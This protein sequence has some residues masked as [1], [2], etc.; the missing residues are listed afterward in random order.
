MSDLKFDKNVKFEIVENKMP[1]GPFAPT[2][3]GQKARV[4]YYTKSGTSYGGGGR[5]VTPTQPVAYESKVLQQSFGSK[6]A[7]QQAEAE[8]YAKQRQEQQK[9]FSKTGGL[10]GV[11]QTSPYFKTGVQDIQTDSQAIRTATT[12]ADQITRQK[13]GVQPGTIGL[14]KT[15]QTK[16]FIGQA[17]DFFT[18]ITA[19]QSGDVE[20]TY[21][22]KTGK[23]TSKIVETQ[24]VNQKDAV[25]SAIK[26][27]EAQGGT[28]TG[29]IRNIPRMSQ[30]GEFIVE[31]AA[32]YP[33]FMGQML[34][35]AKVLQGVSKVTAPLTKPVA[36]VVAK[37]STP[38][39]Q[40]TAQTISG[41]A[42]D[43]YK[44]LSPNVQKGITQVSSKVTPEIVDKGKVLLKTEVTGEALRQAGLYTPE[45]SSATYLAL[46]P[47]RVFKPT[48]KTQKVAEEVYTATRVSYYG[49]T[50]NIVD[51]E[52][53]VIE[54]KKVQ[55]KA[56]IW[57][58]IETP[59]GNLG[60]E[61]FLPGIKVATGF[62]SEFETQVKEKVKDIPEYQALKTPSEKRQYEKEFKD[63]YLNVQQIGG[64]VGQVLVETGGEVTGGGRLYA[65]GPI[66]SR[67]EAAIKFAVASGTT[68]IQE[69]VYTSELG[70]KVEQRKVT[71]QERLTA[72]I[73]GGTIAGG[74]GAAQGYTLGTGTKS[75]VVNIAGELMDFP[76]EPLGDVLGEKV[77]KILNVPDIKVGSSLVKTSYGPSITAQDNKDKQSKRDYSVGQSIWIKTPGV[78]VPGGKTSTAV[79]IKKPSD[80]PPTEPLPGDVPPQEKEDEKEQEK[81]E[82]KEEVPSNVPSFTNVPSTVPVISPQGF[83]LP[84]FGPLGQ[85][86][87]VSR[88][89]RT[90]IYNELEAAGKRFQ[91][92][93]GLG[94]TQPKQ[95]TK[96]NTVLINGKEYKLGKRVKK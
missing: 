84:G 22:T 7:M 77:K 38:V 88:V 10:V 73:M 76:G 30:A 45:V 2:P 14:P 3:E 71:D 34:V 87:G 33:L 12:M 85:A 68:G 4:E 13:T 43:I 56:P 74:F 93:S 54:T 18:G 81:E 32:T 20:I 82:Q 66:K 89:D 94:F 72:A 42:D 28:L 1:V 75:R 62:A 52:G 63:Y 49:G 31:T 91:Q 5:S 48:E 39:V 61:S 37:V 11:G 26:Q 19:P 16:D 70:A 79:D 78:S 46:T 69:G 65:L 29:E 35:G 58:S 55:G 59:I 95:K 44:V 96:P 25:S 6:E 92:L 36:K 23:I 40:K 24:G 80:V 27:I 67:G 41:V 21:K 47:G 53:K 86:R 50:Q 60:A 9:A 15:P 8:Y 17:S 51:K 90:K 57:E 64:T 83:F